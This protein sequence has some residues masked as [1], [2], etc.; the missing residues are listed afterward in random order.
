[1]VE[2]R[3]LK[4]RAWLFEVFQHVFCVPA[5]GADH[6]I[7]GHT[8]PRGHEVRVRGCEIPY[9]ETCTKT[10]LVDGPLHPQQ[11]GDA[12]GRSLALSDASLRSCKF[13]F[14]ELFLFRIGLN[15]ANGLH[16]F[17]NRREIQYLRPVEDRI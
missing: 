12:R 3:H 7:A 10:T 6:G 15:S 1:M 8:D 2:Q 9:A 16:D 17:L 14:H 4:G 13:L 5:V 11:P